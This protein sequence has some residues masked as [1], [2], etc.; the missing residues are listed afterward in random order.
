[1]ET[2]ENSKRI[3]FYKACRYLAVIFFLVAFIA[4]S[5]DDEGAKSSI[6]A[7]AQTFTVNG[8]NNCST[9]SGD[10]STLVMK[11]PYTVSNGSIISKLRIKSTVSDGE[12]EDKINTQF[13]NENSTITWATCFRFGGQDWV[14]YEVQL[15]SNDGAKSNKSKVRIDRPNG[16][17]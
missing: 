7:K 10:G 11:I 1:M 9:S 13:T 12:S 3:I 6:S 2:N 5:N 16:A 4:C 17:N 14:E 15:E 8:I